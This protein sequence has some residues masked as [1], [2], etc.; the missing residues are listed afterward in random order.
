[1]T[2]TRKTWAEF[3]NPDMLRT[4]LISA[5]LFLVAHEMLVDSILR[6]LRS[7]FSDNWTNVDGWVPS[8]DYRAKVLALDPKRKE[9]PLRAS[10]AWLLANDVID[11]L[12]EMVIRTVKDIRNSL[13]HELR[14]IIGGSKPT[15]FA[16]HFG[17]L[18]GLVNKIEKW[19]IINV[20]IHTNPDY[21]GVIIDDDNVIPGTAW[22]MDLLVQIA[23][24]DGD[25]AWKL[26]REFQEH[27]KS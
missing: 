5:G 8:K 13:A 19:W 7:F 6:H 23:L 15:E 10:I 24:G 9:D 20:E 18:M 3:L 27:W 25:E 14:D 17:P 4:K 26:H 22:M 21:D 12:D 16:N 1:M 11:E 2:D